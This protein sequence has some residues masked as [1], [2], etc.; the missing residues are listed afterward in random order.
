MRTNI[1][2]D[3]ELMKTAMSLS[4]IKTKKELIERALESFIRLKK[5]AGIRKLKGKLKWEGNLQDMR[6]DKW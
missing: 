3:D 4:G 2:I 6:A 5:Q 1:T